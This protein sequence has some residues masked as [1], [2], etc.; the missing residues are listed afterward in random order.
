M[1]IYENTSFKAQERFLAGFILNKLWVYR[2]WCG[3]GR[4]PHLGHTSLQNLPKGRPRNEA[5]AI[6]SAAHRLRRFGFIMVFSATGDRHV[7]A[8]RAPEILREG[9]ILVNEFRV[10]TGL[11]A[12]NQTDL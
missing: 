1:P 8:S 11:P 5:G 3:E 10:A 6:L 12:L 7:C 9:L 4:R 2:Y